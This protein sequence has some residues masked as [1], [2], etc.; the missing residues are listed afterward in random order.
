M[1]PIIRIENLSKLYRIGQLGTGSLLQ[2]LKLWSYHLRKGVESIKGNIKNQSRKGARNYIW[3]IKDIN[4][5]VMPGDIVGII[6]K[7]GAGK[8]TLL[9]ILSKVTGPTSG[10]IDY[11]GRIGAL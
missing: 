4:L 10:R 5:D 7:N 9:K 2:D 1:K 11:D 8:S 6:G 3:A